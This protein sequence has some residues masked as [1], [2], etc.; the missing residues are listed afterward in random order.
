MLGMALLALASHAVAATQYIRFGKLIDGKG[1]VWTNVSVVVENDRIRSV[2][3][4]TRPPEG[5][6]IIDLRAYTG[7][8]GM[9]LQP[10]RMPSVRPGCMV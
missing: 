9:R 10:S 4:Y 2:E 6:E 3:P 5:A 7:V 1:K 8:P